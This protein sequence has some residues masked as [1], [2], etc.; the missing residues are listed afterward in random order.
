MKDKFMLIPDV[1][2]GD[3]RLKPLDMVVYAALDSFVNS[4]GEAWPSIPTIARRADVSTA[5][6]KRTLSR[7]ESAEYIVRRR[8][9]TPETKEFESTVYKLL[10]RQ[11]NEASERAECGSGVSGAGSLESGMSALSVQE[12]G[13][14]ECGESA[15]SVQPVGSIGAAN[16]THRTIP[17]E[18]NKNYP[19][20]EQGKPPAPLALFDNEQAD[21]AEIL[22][23]VSE[24]PG[25]MRQTAEYLLLKTGRT[26]LSEEEISALRALDAGHYP[27]RVQKEI[28]T[29]IE[30]FK[31]IG[32]PPGTLTFCYIA[33]SLANQPSRAPK[34]GV[35]RQRC[36]PDY[37]ELNV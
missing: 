24:A 6:V 21:D 23:P 35:P 1:M 17:N 9:Y 20:G 16:Y 27:A 19:S 5:T 14:L 28:G 8:R 36:T 18:L 30:R 7:L 11:K 37:S 32:R 3:S 22:F 4:D 33:E 31:R 29:A 15:L 25:A 12:V 2:L 26:G 10:F 34:S 13:S